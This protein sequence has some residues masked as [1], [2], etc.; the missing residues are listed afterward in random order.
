MRRC[1]AFRRLSSPLP[2]NRDLPRGLHRRPAAREAEVAE[3]P[4][5]HVRRLHFCGG[6]AGHVQSV[7]ACST[8]SKSSSS[9][10]HWF[11]TGTAPTFLVKLMAKTYFE[12]FLRMATGIEAS[13]I[14]IHRI[15]VRHEH[16][17]AAAVSVAALFSTIIDYNK[18][19]R[20]YTLRVP[21]RGGAVRFI[22]SCLPPRDQAI[23]PRR[24]RS[25]HRQVVATGP[26]DGAGRVLKDRR[27]V[28]TKKRARLPGGNVGTC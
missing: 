6:H 20:I 3:N 27:G 10:T 24:L 18:E 16:G 17:G 22:T 23:P 15:P 12:S 9:T 25:T 28:S 26:A 2:S 8:R 4:P 13:D 19:F 14:G 7:Q 21:K 5:A 11:Q 1:A